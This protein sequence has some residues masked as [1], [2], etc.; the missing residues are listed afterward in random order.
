MNVEFIWG[1]IIFWRDFRLTNVPLC[2]PDKNPIEH[3]RGGREIHQQ[4]PTP[5]FE[6]SRNTFKTFIR[7][8][9]PHALQDDFAKRPLQHP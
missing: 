3:V 2:S 8:N 5:Q 4:P 6:D 7:S 9:R 1:R